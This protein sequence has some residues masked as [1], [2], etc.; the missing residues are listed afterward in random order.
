MLETLLEYIEYATA[1]PLDFDN[2]NHATMG[3]EYDV[4]PI[5]VIIQHVTIEF[6]P[7]ADV[8][9]RAGVFGVTSSGAI[10]HVYGRSRVHQVSPTELS[11]RFDIVGG[12]HVPAEERIVVVISRTNAAGTGGSSTLSAHIRQGDESATLSP[13]ES[14]DDSATDFARVKHVI[15]THSFPVNG[16]SRHDHG[17]G[18]RGNIRISY[19]VVLNH[20]SLVGDGTV[21]ASHFDSESAAD[22]EV[23]TADGS[24]VSAWEALPDASTT[25]AGVIEI[26]TNAEA[27]AV[28]ATHRALVPANIGH[29]DLEDF[30]SGTAASGQVPTANGSGR[31]HL[32][33]P[34]RGSVRG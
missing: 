20:G 7:R 25:A 19:K 24:G 34:R 18:I 27:G 5:D 22:G 8:Y 10:D 32:G 31:H 9:Y 29:I 30:D 16:S 14:Y 1:E 12:A 15:Y 3:E 28:T 13:L 4:G 2:S 6:D 26:A 17:T 23:L 33:S 21:N 11:Q